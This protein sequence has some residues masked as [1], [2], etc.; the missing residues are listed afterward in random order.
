MLSFYNPKKYTGLVDVKKRFI[1]EKDRSD[2]LRKENLK[3]KSLL[4][5][6]LGVNVLKSIQK[7]VPTIFFLTRSHI[8]RLN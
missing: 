2:R 7:G 5:I 3:K 6:Y 1:Y 4:K 8:V